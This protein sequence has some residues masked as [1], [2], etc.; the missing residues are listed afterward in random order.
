MAKNQEGIVMQVTFEEYTETRTAHYVA[1]A[2]EK[3]KEA[4]AKDTSYKVARDYLKEFTADEKNLEV[5][6]EIAEALSRLFKT[7]RSASGP[8]GPKATPKSAIRS[9]ILAMI[10]VEPVSEQEV[11]MTSM[12]LGNAWG[13][14]EM[15]DFIKHNL[16]GVAPEDRAWVTFETVEGDTMGSYV[17]KG[18]GP[19]AP[20]GWEGYVPVDTE[21]DL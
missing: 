6:P 10:S 5:V 19:E 8:K 2:E 4:N 1:L 18:T 17:L 3:G 16:K 7:V 11:F 13:R 14:V 20:E 21:V 9:A 15:K 12:E